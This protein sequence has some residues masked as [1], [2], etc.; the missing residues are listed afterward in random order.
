MSRLIVCSEADLPSVN[1]RDAL[2]RMHGWED[3]GSAE[4]ASYAAHGDDVMMTFPDTH[5][6]HDGIDREAEAFGVKV[7]SVIVM[8]RHSSKSGRPAL[9]AHPIGNYH[10]ADF[11]GRPE[12]VVRA[13][14]AGMSDAVRRIHA[15]NGDPEVQTCFE[16]THHGPWLDRPTFYIEIGSDESHWGNV[17]SA[18]LLAHVISDLEPHPEYRALVGIGGGH[19]APRFTE[20]VLASRVNFG[21]MIPNYQ[22]EGRDDEDIARMIRGACAATGTDSV[23]IHR[24]SM[25][26]PEEHRIAD[27][28]VS[29][30]FETVK[31][32]DFEPLRS[33][34]VHERPVEGLSEDGLPELGDVPAVDHRDVDAGLPGDLHPE[35]VED[36]GRGG[37]VLLVDQLA[38]ASDVHPGD[39]L[40]VRVLA[41]IGGVHRVHRG[42]VDHAVGAHGAGDHHGDG[43]RCVPGL[44]PAHHHDP[45][46]SGG[47][48]EL[49]C[50][51]GDA[52][53]HVPERE[54][55]ELGVEPGG[56]DAQDV[57]LVGRPAELPPGGGVV[58]RGAPSADDHGDL[59]AVLDG[60]QHLGESGYVIGIIAS[61]DQNGPPNGDHDLVYGTTTTNVNYQAGLP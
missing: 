57:E 40:G 24:K 38:Q 47:A 30:G 5:I 26:G 27:I 61:G 51:L 49:L 48:C 16:V 1:M 42:G 56:P 50:G 4:G 37:V 54:R 29:E 32:K 18:E 59:H 41:G 46:G 44:R 21:H 34:R 55:Q 6:Y 36:A 2:L 31:S 8:S 58:A 11:G 33:V 28:A 45:A 23:Y 53:G 13:D 17:A 12:A 22:L 7:D 43:V 52:V 15:L 35:G 9:T 10:Q 60:Q 14:P 39:L 19:Y 20:A 25:K 3:L